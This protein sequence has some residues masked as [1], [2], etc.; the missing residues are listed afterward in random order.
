MAIPP[1]VKGD[2]VRT[3]PSGGVWNEYQR[4][5]GKIE[6]LFH[7]IVAFIHIGFQYRFFGVLPCWALE[8]SFNYRLNLK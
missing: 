5:V 4:N 6:S 8:K 7:H 1:N 2:S 3:V